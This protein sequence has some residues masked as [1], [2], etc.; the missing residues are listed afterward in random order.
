LASLPE[1]LDQTYARILRRIITDRARNPKVATKVFQWVAGAKR[2]LTVDEMAEAISIEPDD[3]T[4]ENVAQ[5]YPMDKFKVLE[6]CANLIVLNN[7]DTIQFAHSTVLDFL[8]SQDLIPQVCHQFVIDRKALN[9]RL[10]HTCI[11]YLSFPCFEQSVLK[12]H[13][14]TKCTP[15]SSRDIGAQIPLILSMSNSAFERGIGNTVAQ[16]AR[17]KASSLPAS[18]VDLKRTVAS[19]PEEVVPSSAAAK[20]MLNYIAENWW[21]HCSKVEILELSVGEHWT[22]KFDELCFHRMFHV[23]H[24]PWL[25]PDFK[26]S[27]LRARDEYEAPFTWAVTS[28]HEALQHFIMSKLYK[29]GL[30]PATPISWARKNLCAISS[31]T[32]IQVYIIAAPDVL[33]SVPAELYIHFPDPLLVATCRGYTKVCR[34]LLDRKRAFD[35]ESETLEVERASERWCRVLPPGL[36]GAACEL[37]HAEIIKLF[38]QFDVTAISVMQGMGPRVFNTRG[39]ERPIENSWRDEKWTWTPIELA[40]IHGHLLIINTLLIGIVSYL[41]WDAQ[42]HQYTRVRLSLLI[43]FHKTIP[44]SRVA[45][46]SMLQPLSATR[47]FQDWLLLYLNFK[48]PTESRVNRQWIQGNCF[49]WDAPTWKMAALLHASATGRTNAVQRI[50]DINASGDDPKDYTSETKASATLLTFTPGLGVLCVGLGRYAL[51]AAFEEGRGAVA[52]LLLAAGGQ[53]LRE[54]ADGHVK[55]II[56]IQGKNMLHIAAEK[57]HIEMVEALLL[58][59]ITGSY[60]NFLS[61]EGNTP[62]YYACVNDKLDIAQILV[63]AGANIRIPGKDGPLLHEASALG[64]VETVEFLVKCGVDV[65]MLDNRGRTAMEVAVTHTQNTD[66]LCLPILQK[67]LDSCRHSPSYQ[68]YLDKALFQASGRGLPDVVEWLL[69]EGADCNKKFNI[70]A[71]GTTPLAEACARVC[72]GIGNKARYRK[73]I[74][75]LLTAGAAVKVRHYCGDLV[76][77]AKKTPLYHASHARDKEVVQLL[78]AA[79]A[80]CNIRARKGRTV[81]QEIERAINM[82]R[83]LRSMSPAFRS[84]YVLDNLWV[85]WEDIDPGSPEP[86]RLVVYEEILALFRKTPPLASP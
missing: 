14:I 42:P 28:C 50:L 82:I 43:D 6:N 3:Q 10:A 37:G 26:D 76:C 84:D 59:D 33:F 45:D 4:W 25:L 34:T 16:Y 77:G 67:L 18:R 23:Q 17:I 69:V 21:K 55:Q 35:H 68:A 53:K 12:H 57:G 22:S 62:L 64:K 60:V 20:Y 72:A 44:I 47:R 29:L 65:H 70:S 78:L 27:A 49:E 32:H 1:G 74:K 2:P 41:D 30:P 66:H 85:K 52:K 40:F 7:D 73:V 9:T 39:L 46:G 13:K 54:A 56:G 5:R 71:S 15:L 58:S 61:S 83:R 19:A 31:S 86:S 24:L 8:C 81:P 79:G 38:L 63:T 36:L 75:H 51:L 48:F 80:D 11:T